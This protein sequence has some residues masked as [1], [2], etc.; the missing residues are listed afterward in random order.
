MGTELVLYIL[1][2]PGRSLFSSSEVTI[3]G[4]RVRGWRASVFVQRSGGRVWQILTW[5]FD[6]ENDDEKEEK[7][8]TY[9]LADIPYRIA[10]PDL[11]HEPASEVRRI[12]SCSGFCR[13][14]VAGSN[15]CNDSLL[16]KQRTRAARSTSNNMHIS[17]ASRSNLRFCW[18]K[19][20]WLACTSS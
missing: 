11:S 17:K 2:V 15:L 13:R 6:Y 10:E 3:K 19:Y 18:T 5:R 4:L 1:F 8:W 16:A 14:N 12:G 7:W 20:T 9:C